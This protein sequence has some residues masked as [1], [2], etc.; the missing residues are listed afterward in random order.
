MQIMLTRRNLLKTIGGSVL[1][2]GQCHARADVTA[3]TLATGRY[4]AAAVT[5]GDA[6]YV[7]G[8]STVKSCLVTL[9]SCA[10]RARP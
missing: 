5:V 4:G 2:A 8:G 10:P 9:R 1:T 7:L 6:I 3:M